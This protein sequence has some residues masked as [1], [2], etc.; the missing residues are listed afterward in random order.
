[1]T[2]IFS[3]LTFAFW[4]IADLFYKKGNIIN[5]KFN[6]IKTGIFVGIVMGIHALVYLIFN[7]ISVDFVDI[8]RYLPVSFCYILSMVIG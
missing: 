3:L 7:G 5:E 8:L 4:G 1:M 2:M 6:D